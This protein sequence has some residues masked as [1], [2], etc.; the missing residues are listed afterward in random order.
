MAIVHETLEYRV[1]PVTRYIVT[2]Y[3]SYT[4]DQP[5]CGGAG[6]SV[7]GEFDNEATAE[8]IRATLAEQEH[9]RRRLQD[10]RQPWICFERTHEIGAKVYYCDSEEQAL[11]QAAEFSAEFGTEWRIA[12]RW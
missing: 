6:S 9:Q 1:K 11:R 7:V 4:E 2:R 5:G 12:R 3:H 8:N 10:M